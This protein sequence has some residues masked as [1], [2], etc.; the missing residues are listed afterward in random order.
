MVGHALGVVAGAHGHHAFHVSWQLRELVTRAALFE[1]GG[2]LQVFEFEEDLRAGDQ[3]ERFALHAG[4][5]E[6]MGRDA[7]GSGLDISERDHLVI[8]AACWS[9]ARLMCG[10]F[11]TCSANSF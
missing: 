7:L 8:V 10:E 1:A 5:I 2:E 3:R 9:N 4:R 6:H 11:H